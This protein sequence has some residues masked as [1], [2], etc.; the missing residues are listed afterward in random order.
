MNR[1][2][3]VTAL[4]LVPQT[5]LDTL[6]ATQLRI[7]AALKTLQ[8]VGSKAAHPPSDYLTATEF[9]RAVKICRSKFD[10]L[11][12]AGQIKVIRKRRKLYVPLLEVERY[13]N[14]PSVA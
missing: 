14:D 12:A 11:A 13:F 4:V 6:K 9:M 3:S 10:Q 5:D 8:T 7:L 2:E 1:V